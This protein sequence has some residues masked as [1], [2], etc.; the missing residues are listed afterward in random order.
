M[1]AT[2]FWYV[3]L[4]PPAT[5]AAANEAI[6]GAVDRLRNDP[7]FGRWWDEWNATPDTVLGPGPGGGSPSPS[8]VG[9]LDGIR[10][11][12]L[13][14]AQLLEF[15]V[16]ETEATTWDLSDERPD[17][18]DGLFVA[19][20]GLPVT[21]L[22]LMGLGPLRTSWLPGAFGVFALSPEETAKAADGM[23]RAHAMSPADRA[24]ALARMHDWLSMG[25]DHSVP[26]QHLLE[27]LPDVAASAVSRSTG[28]I[29]ILARAD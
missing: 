14:E 6:A 2:S 19:L 26:V 27:G 20:R 8:A 16:P 23:R 10:Q 12:E 9:L 15:S 24:S 22:L 13:T 4:A 1:V 29:S 25:N 11:L 28:M 5:I 18:C 3:S 7:D 21:S 17:P